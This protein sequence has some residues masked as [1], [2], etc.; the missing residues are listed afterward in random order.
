MRLYVIVA[1]FYTAI[2]AGEAYFGLGEDAL[3]FG[4]RLGWAAVIVLWC[5]IGL[6]WPLFRRTP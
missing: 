6:M 5:L 2:Q 3:F 4:T 1:I